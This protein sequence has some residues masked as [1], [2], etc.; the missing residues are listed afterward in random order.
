LFPDIGALVKIAGALLPLMATQDPKASWGS[1][2]SKAKTS[3]DTVIADLD[4]RFSVLSTVFSDACTWKCQD[5][6]VY[7]SGVNLRLRFVEFWLLN[8]DQTLSATQLVELWQALFESQS[9]ETVRQ[10]V[11]EFFING[12]RASRKFYSD[13]SAAVFFSNALSKSL[14]SPSAS[15]AVFRVF[16]VFFL[17]LN[18]RKGYVTVIEAPVQSVE[19]VLPR[20]VVTNPASL[21]GIDTIWNAALTIESSDIWVPVAVLLLRCTLQLAPMVQDKQQAN[22]SNLQSMFVE[23]CLTALPSTRALLLLRMFIDTVQTGSNGSLAVAGGNVGAI[24]LPATIQSLLS[25]HANEAMIVVQFAVKPGPDTVAFSSQYPISA[26]LS[27]LRSHAALKIDHPESLTELQFKGF[28]IN[29]YRLAVSELRGNSSADCISVQVWK[30]NQVSI[31]TQAASSACWIANQL[32]GNNAQ[33]NKLFALLESNSTSIAQAAWQLLD[34][35]PPSPAISARFDQIIS[36]STESVAASSATAK[37]TS[38]KS[39]KN[40]WG[41]E[42]NAQMPVKL[43]YSLRILEAKVLPRWALSDSRT[44]D[45]DHKD[46]SDAVDESARAKFSAV[47]LALDFYSDFELF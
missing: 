28:P 14:C 24:K 41:V 4:E 27:S 2:P 39:E 40:P 44:I 30:R 16:A 37:A 6:T 42:L 26:A 13:S 21:I 32:V 29:D 5:S 19:F 31:Q 47:S 15:L 12:T 9:V 17:E 34:V 18:Q 22:S 10:C 23:R 35:L 20:F 38:P 46:D 43:L 36:A 3:I 8:S 7:L 1:K 33:Y 25:A 11:C 45:S